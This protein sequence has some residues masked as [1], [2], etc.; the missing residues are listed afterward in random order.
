MS[1]FNN[2]YESFSLFDIFQL[3]RPHVRLKRERA[4]VRE[5]ARVCVREGEGEEQ[6]ALQEHQE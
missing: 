6:V 2:K 1:V 5:C 3:V 4:R